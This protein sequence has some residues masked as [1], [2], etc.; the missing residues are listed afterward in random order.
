[1]QHSY[2]EPPLHGLPPGPA[3]PMRPSSRSSLPGAR[4]PDAAASASQMRGVQSGSVSPGTQNAAANASQMRGVQSGSVSPGA[5]AAYAGVG[6]GEGGMMA[7]RPPTRRG[8]STPHSMSALSMSRGRSGIMSPGGRGAG[9]HLMAAQLAGQSKLDEDLHLLQALEKIT[10]ERRNEINAE[11]ESM[12]LEDDTMSSHNATTGYE[13]GSAQP[14]ATEAVRVKKLQ[15][16]LNHAK[17]EASRA[18][19]ERAEAMRTRHEVAVHFQNVL[20]QQQ[21]Q[22]PS[23][24]QGETEGKAGEAQGDVCAVIEDDAMRQRC[25]DLL[26][27]ILGTTSEEQQVPPA[28]VVAPAAPVGPIHVQQQMSSMQS[29]LS[30]ME[31]VVGRLNESLER[32]EASRQEK[33][34][35]NKR[36]QALENLVMKK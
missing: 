30:K 3:L 32:E 18:E 35:M 2:Q 24:Q 7:G 22:V 8:L 14:S 6:A 29:M 17:A 15:E 9:Q 4:Q 23:D 10:K 16:E 31:K 1:M 25:R 34:A 21:K 20:A 13:R 27:D 19:A 11:M 33:E 5:Y 12:H 28:Y 36:L 26:S